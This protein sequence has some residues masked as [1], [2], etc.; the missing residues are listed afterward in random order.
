MRVA[1][2]VSLLL[3]VLGI[4]ICVAQP[5]GAG[6]T[7]AE[8]T[9]VETSVEGANLTY[10][11]Q[12][13]SGWPGWIKVNWV[14]KTQ[15]DYRIFLLIP[16][17]NIP[18]NNSLTPIVFTNEYSYFTGG[19]VVRDPCFTWPFTAPAVEDYTEYRFRL[20][21]ISSNYTVQNAPVWTNQSG[22][23]TVMNRAKITFGN[24]Y[25]HEYPIII[26]VY[27]PEGIRKK[28]EQQVIALQEELNN[29]RNAYTSQLSQLSQR[30]SYLESELSKATGMLKQYNVTV[31]NLTSL[32]QYYYV[33]GKGGV[34]LGLV[35]FFLIMMFILPYIIYNMKMKEYDDSFCR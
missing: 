17:E 7:T 15:H 28:A 33:L 20:I 27:N 22:I 2:A 12:L 18:A 6:Q 24:A 1:A 26:K 19:V 5:Q 32:F 25:L 13:I 34:S 21:V 10:T 29:L 16:P 11:A 23:I 9:I 31:A 8:G 4:H 14:P 30:V 3:L 35:V